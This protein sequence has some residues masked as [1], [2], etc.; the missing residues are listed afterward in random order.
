MA[1]ALIPAGMGLGK[2]FTL[3]AA[4]K[5]CKLLT[6]KVVIELLLS[7]LWGNILE[8]WVDLAQSDCP[9]TISEEQEF[10]PLQRQNSVPHCLTQIL[11]TTPLGQ[12]ALI[13]AL[14]PILVVTIR[15]VAET[16]KSVINDMTY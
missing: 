3:V 10:N 6:E 8:A 2:T 12:P 15:G 9:R 7:I 11:E 5:M 16:S 14:K 4:A 1:G 13:S